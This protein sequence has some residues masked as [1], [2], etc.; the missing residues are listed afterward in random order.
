MGT[1]ALSPRV[2]TPSSTLDTM[3]AGM[4]GLRRVIILTMLVNVLWWTT[5]GVTFL[6]ELRDP[7]HPALRERRTRSG[8]YY[9]STR[10]A[11]SGYT[12]LFYG[13]PVV[14]TALCAYRITRTREVDRALG[15]FYYAMLMG[16]C[17][18][19]L[20]FVAMRD[21]MAATIEMTPAA[22]ALRAAWFGACAAAACAYAF[23]PPHRRG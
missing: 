4:N 20:L 16:V 21:G 18:A 17:A 15:A 12:M 3:R 10:A 23:A 14:L 11:Q 7:D 1:S 13:L 6:R 5:S 22:V 9:R 19:G 8:H 2:W